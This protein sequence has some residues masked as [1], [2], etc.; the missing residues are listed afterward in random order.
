MSRKIRLY[1]IWFQSLDLEHKIEYNR[2]GSDDD[3]NPIIHKP[4]SPGDIYF[5]DGSDTDQFGNKWTRK[6]VRISQLIP[7]QYFQFVRR[8][9]DK[10]INGMCPR[11]YPNITHELVAA[12]RTNDKRYIVLTINE[13]GDPEY[14]FPENRGDELV[15]PIVR[16]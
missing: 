10:Q 14:F 12:A 11:K 9:P 2:V 3:G 13:K 15:Y 7:G 4:D 1:E 8:E 6:S 16:N 5:L